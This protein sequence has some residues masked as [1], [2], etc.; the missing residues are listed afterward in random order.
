MPVFY[1]PRHTASPGTT[2]NPA[3]L[4]LS[5]WRPLLAVTVSTHF[6]P[7]LE[8]HTGRSIVCFCS[9]LHTSG[10]RT[11]TTPQLGFLGLL[12][13]FPVLPH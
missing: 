8:I 1:E 9:F 5:L 7:E 11:R 10:G 2:E 4:I 13:P 6:Q 3:G 12:L